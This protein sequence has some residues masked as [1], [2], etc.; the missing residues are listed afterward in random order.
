MFG[1]GKIVF[2]QRTT[3]WYTWM[4][5][6]KDINLFIYKSLRKHEDG[7]VNIHNEVA[8]MLFGCNTNIV[9]AVDGGSVMYVTAYISK[10]TQHDDKKHL[11]MPQE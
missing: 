6:K 7:F 1:C 5:E 4:G 2:E 11:Q 8:S 9:N 10:N 3:S